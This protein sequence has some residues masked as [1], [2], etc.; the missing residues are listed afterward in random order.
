[1]HSELFSKHWGSVR[2]VSEGSVLELRVSEGSLRGV[3]RGVSPR[4]VT[5]TISGRPQETDGHNYRTLLICSRIYFLNIEHQSGRHLKTQKPRFRQSSA[6]KQLPTPPPC[7]AEVTR[8]RTPGSPD[9]R[10]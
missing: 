9:S 4:I 10:Q 5:S 8:R 1:M 3:I 6:A 7:R 2:G